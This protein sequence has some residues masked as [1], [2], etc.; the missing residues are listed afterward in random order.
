MEAKRQCWICYGEETLLEGDEKSNADEPSEWVQP[1]R[2]RGSTG[3]VHQR[4]LLS[5]VDRLAPTSTPGPTLSTPRVLCPQCQTPYRFHDKLVF[6][7]WI[8]RLLDNIETRRRDVLLW[9]AAGGAAFGVYLAALAYGAGVATI[10]GGAG[11]ELDHLIHIITAVHLRPSLNSQFHI[12]PS[13]S[14][15]LKA[16][17]VLQVGRILIGLP[18]LPLYVL[19]IRYRPLSLLHP[20]IPMLVCPSWQSLQWSWPPT[21]SLTLTLLPLLNLAYRSIFRGCLFPALRRWLIPGLT[22]VEYSYS[23]YHFNSHFNYRQSSPRSLSQSPAPSNIDDHIEDDSIP[24]SPEISLAHE[25]DDEDE[26][27]AS[28]TSSIVNITSTLVFPFAAAG[29]G[30]LLAPRSVSPLNRTLIGGTVLLLA[31]ELSKTLTWYQRAIS[32]R[33]RKILRFEI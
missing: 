30:F 1:C 19:S 23:Y 4:C 25:G 2:C 32:H 18:L 12:S 33:N 29:L 13:S 6:P 3:W 10:A 11:G 21:P 22:K 26:E 17:E 7:A 31:S 20:L 16:E 24:T 9:C 28:F 15:P 27:L 8:L 5:W 14:S